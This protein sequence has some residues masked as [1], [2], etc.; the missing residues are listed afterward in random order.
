MSTELIDAPGADG[1]AQEGGGDLLEELLELLE[2]MPAQRPIATRLLSLCDDDKTSA[3]DLAA[4]ISADTT[5]TARLMR[6]SNSVY[7]GLSGRVRNPTFAVTVTGYA[8]VRSLAVAAATGIDDP[9]SLP[10]D[11]WRRAGST[12]IAA[13]EVARYFGLGAPDTF[14]VGILAPLGQALLWQY[15]RERYTAVLAESPTRRTLLAS[16]RRVYGRTHTDV[17]AAA[18]EAWSF[19]PDMCDALRLLDSPVPGPPLTA[20]LRVAV[21]VAERLTNSRHVRTAVEVLSLG[22]LREADV[23]WVSGRVVSQVDDLVRAVAG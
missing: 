4:A 7:Y 3:A 8:T 5:L 2:S 14:C 6:L 16:E 15:D 23:E 11:F 9:T 20:C 10:P 19:P 1:A 21:E 13:G 12:A 18:L 22:A 17:S